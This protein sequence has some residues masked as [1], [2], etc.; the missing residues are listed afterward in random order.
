MEQSATGQG[1]GAV[2]SPL[3]VPILWGKEKAAGI[4]SLSSTEGR[5]GSCLSS[6][7]VSARPR[8]CAGARVSHTQKLATVN[9][10]VGL[11]S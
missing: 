8:V 11:D 6:V 5:G 7:L 9:K 2:M 1:C 10:P 4:S 3:L